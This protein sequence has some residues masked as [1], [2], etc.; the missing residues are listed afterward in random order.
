M[1][2]NGTLKKK[3]ENLKGKSFVTI[4]S[5]NFA[6]V[7]YVISCHLKRQPCNFEPKYHI[8]S[9]C[10]F[11]AHVFRPYNT[12]IEECTNSCHRFEDNYYKYLVL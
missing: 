12:T 8:D 10:F 5:L 7:F 3:Y 4:T 2:R 9:H 6:V 11:D 1:T